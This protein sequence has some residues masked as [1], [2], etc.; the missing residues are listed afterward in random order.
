VVG[1]LTW[2]TLS[3]QKIQLHRDEMKHVREISQQHQTNTP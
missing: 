3:L 2:M 1:M